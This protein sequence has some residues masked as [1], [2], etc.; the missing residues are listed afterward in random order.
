MLPSFQLFLGGGG[1]VTISFVFVQKKCIDPINHVT[2][3]IITEGRRT[4]PKITN[5]YILL[6]S[7][8]FKKFKKLYG[9]VSAGN[10]IRKKK[11]G[12][13]CKG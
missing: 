13:K 11:K 12:G 3:K 8:K 6:S 2:A 1:K 9:Q 5:D 7:K 4:L 10:P